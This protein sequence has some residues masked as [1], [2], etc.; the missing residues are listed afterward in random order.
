M[1]VHSLH[2]KGDLGHGITVA[3]K[4]VSSRRAP[5]RKIR[6]EAPP[7]G[8]PRELTP[9]LSL[10]RVDDL[11]PAP[12]WWYKRKD[13]NQARCSDGPPPLTGRV[14]PTLPSESY[15]PTH[16]IFKNWPGQDGR[17]SPTSPCQPQR[18]SLL[19]VNVE[20]RNSLYRHPA[21]DTEVTV[22]TALQDTGETALPK[23]SETGGE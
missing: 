2:S 16:S 5:I 12:R 1:L 8:A 21:S 20:I 19:D 10:L 11:P 3:R 15:P 22:L 9:E 13:S 4:A 14:T 7:V 18:W 6:H 17:A 23:Q